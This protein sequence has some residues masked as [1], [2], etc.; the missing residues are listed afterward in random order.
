MGLTTTNANLISWD[1]IDGDGFNA[2]QSLPL[3]QGKMHRLPC[4]I[5][6]WC[7]KH[8]AVGAV[9]WIR[10]NTPTRKAHLQQAFR[11]AAAAHSGPKPVQLLQ[12]VT[13]QKDHM[14]RVSK[15]HRPTALAPDGI[16]CRCPTF[17]KSCPPTSVTLLLFWENLTPACQPPSYIYNC[18]YFWST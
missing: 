12:C 15:R 3:K 6:G 2:K 4:P 11:M 5:E 16:I 1:S 7:S 8:V 10:T 18:K 13:L 17:S 14:A 9:V